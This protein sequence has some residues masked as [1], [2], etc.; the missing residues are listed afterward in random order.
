MQGARNGQD[1]FRT[2]AAETASRRIKPFEKH[3]S[4]LQG[5]GRNRVTILRCQPRAKV[6]YTILSDDGKTGT[7]TAEDDRYDGFVGRRHRATISE[8]K[9]A[10]QLVPSS[11]VVFKYSGALAKIR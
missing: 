2:N 3:S 7:N 5:A 11:A 10:I 1:I 4:E 9:I 6:T 8:K